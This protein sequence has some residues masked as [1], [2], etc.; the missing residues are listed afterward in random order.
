MSNVNSWMLATHPLL[1]GMR[2]DYL[3]TL[4]LAAT[5]VRIEAGRR[6]FEEGDNATRFWLIRSGGINLDQYVPGEG[7]A[8]IESIGM[9]ELLG[10]SWL[11][12]PYQWRFGAVTVSAVSA[13]EFDAA[14]VY[15]SCLTDPELDHEITVR[16]ARVLISRLQATRLRLLRECHVS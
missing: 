5:D 4:S 8:V 15:A 16:V 6:L 7:R 12:P 10:W 9:G 13:F 2:A 3:A 11:F 1:R 14:A